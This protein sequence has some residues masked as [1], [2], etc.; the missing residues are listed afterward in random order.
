MEPN[1]KLITNQDLDLHLFTSEEREYWTSI[2]L[3][4]IPN[5]AMSLSQDAS[6]NK[7]SN[8]SSSPTSR[9]FRRILNIKRKKDQDEQ[10]QPSLTGIPKLR[11]Q[12]ARIVDA[13][14]VLE[15]VRQ[16]PKAT[17]AQGQSRIKPT[18][19][20]MDAQRAERD[21][22][23]HEEHNGQVRKAL[24]ELAAPLAAQE[25]RVVPVKVEDQVLYVVT[26]VSGENYTVQL[27]PTLGKCN[28]P[29]KFFCH[30]LL[31]VRFRA[32]V[33]ADLKI[34]SNAK[35]PQ[36]ADMGIGFAEKAFSAPA[37]PSAATEDPV[38][39]AKGK[40]LTAE[41][42]KCMHAKILLSKAI[43]DARV[44]DL[45]LYDKDKLSCAELYAREAERTMALEDITVKFMDA[46]QAQK[47]FSEE[48][49]KSAGIACSKHSE[50]GL[51]H[52]KED[53][54]L[55]LKIRNQ[56]QHDISQALFYLTLYFQ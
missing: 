38:I 41:V 56:L 33:Q 10:P 49:R 23:P 40:A 14:K 29:S 35:L 22:K 11:Q 15:E 39:T 25:F 48:V 18:I 50:K 21:K 16:V 27:N 45:E 24:L 19:E 34:P 8:S 31:A 37:A 1:H 55:D 4:Q 20:E 44:D 47:D 3:L 12:L 2:I 7:T 51:C 32:G 28:C 6:F 26:D 13:I 9:F 43:M 17:T 54:N 46:R 52:P 5:S 53:L 36:P 42:R 30:H